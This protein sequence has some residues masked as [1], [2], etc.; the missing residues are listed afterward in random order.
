MVILVTAV[1]V[2]VH[3][4]ALH[5]RVLAFMIEEVGKST[6]GRFDLGDF[7]FRW[8]GLR[9][10]LDRPLLHGTEPAGTPPLFAAN[11]V[12]VNFSV[13]SWLG[14]E[15]RLRGV[16][17]DHPAVHLIVDRYGHSNI[18]EPAGK[19]SPSQPVDVFHLG[20][21]HFGLDQGTVLFND[22]Q[23]PLDADL[24]NVDAQARYVGRGPKYECSLS[25]H[26]GQVRYGHWN[27]AAHSLDTQFEA[28]PAGLETHHLLLTVGSSQVS[29]QGSL[30]DYA[31]PEVQATYQASL[32]LGD[33]RRILKLSGMP[34]GKLGTH[35]VLHYASTPGQS[36]LKSIVLDGQVSG[37]EI[38][39]DLPQ[40][41]TAVRLESARYHLAG[42]TA[43]VRDAVAALLGGQVTADLSIENLTA[44][45][46]AYHLASALK[47]ISLGEVS[48]ALRGR[49]PEPV[50]IAG[51]VDGQADLTWTGA[52]GSLMVRSDLDLRGSATAAS[53]AIPVQGAVHLNYDAARQVL[54]FQQSDLRTPH[55]EVR[56][57]GTLSNQSQLGIQARSDDLHEVDELILEVR[58]VNLGSGSETPPLPL[59]LQGSATFDGALQGSLNAPQLSGR[60]T[61]ER[62]QAE[63]T[64]WSAFR[65]QVSVSPWAVS[66]EQAVLDVPQSGGHIAFDFHTSLHGWSYQ[67]STPLSIDASAVNVPLAQLMRMA[68]LDY[69]IS[70]MLSG[71]LSFKGTPMHPVGQGSAQMTAVEIKDEPVESVNVEVQG[72]GEALHSTISLRAAAGS[73][74]AQVTYY[75]ANQAYDLQLG[76]RRIHLERLRTLSDLRLPL[77]G[78]VTATAQGRGTLDQPQIQIT[79]DS[80]QLT[81]NLPNGAQEAQS[82]KAQLNV[83]K[84][85]ASFTANANLGGTLE[86]RGTVDL[87]GDYNASASL[88]TSKIALAP[89]LDRYLPAEASDLQG[90][91]EIHATVTGPLK[92]PA[93][94]VAH[95]EIS[96]LNLAYQNISLANRAP[97]KLGYARGLL[98]I[99][100]V[101][102]EGSSTD[103]R[104]DGSVPLL[105]ALRTTPMRINA[106]GTVDLKILKLFAPNVDSSGQVTLSFSAQGNRSH[107]EFQGEVSVLNGTIYTTSLPLGLSNLNG[108]L[109]VVG[110]HLQVRQLTGQL[111]G[112]D[113]QVT[114]FVSYQPNI[115][116]A[117]ALNASTVR[118]RYPLGVRTILDTNL[119]LTGTPKSAR[120]TGRVLI[121]RLSLTKEFDLLT[122][123]DQLTAPA[124]PSPSNSFESH[125]RL[126][127]GVQSTEELSLASSKLSMQGSANLRMGGTAATPVIVGRAVVNAG[128]VY[129]R[130]QRYQVQQGVFD[131][132]DPYRTEPTVNL[133][134]S[135]NIDQYDLTMNLVGPMDRLR[136]HYS[137]V[138]PLPPVDIINLLA[139]GRT[140]TEQ[141]A[142]AGS[143]SN[144]M[145]AESIL[146]QGLSSAV[147]S[148]IERLVGIS[149]LQIDPLLGGS[150]SEPGARLAIQQRVTRNLS[151]TYATDVRTTGRE[152]IQVE[153]R[154]TRRWSLSLTRD[155]YGTYGIDVRGRKTF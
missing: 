141:A 5:R 23:V 43:Q 136:I 1:Y 108:Q 52:L 102:F 95:V 113:V 6:G 80:P 121:N 132:I 129:F 22:Q 19:P 97:L 3:S 103:L 70:G 17:I 26:D 76:A 78:L 114:G 124:P 35:G 68:K 85:H 29:A 154:L 31:K 10:D 9:L 7:N 91:A 135:T 38:A 149:N 139:T 27:P 94:V 84:R 110:N 13:I 128:E 56:L 41:K 90:Q 87:T 34:A 15:V 42:G 77:E 138:P 142:T 69:P 106:N 140:A 117:L 8:S 55:A 107:P 65:A 88:N 45:R 127:V 79:L 81:Y 20:I 47:Q 33:L 39:V 98:T 25:Y 152:V 18:P 133:T 100:P 37:S 92:R 60:I 63:G 28:A 4:P 24:R 131:F 49:V 134:L 11:R 145:G 62:L 122:I 66:V 48:R 112:G 101:S 16:T 99:E 111:G 151:F 2:A 137:S 50:P 72:V 115:T 123:A 105:P 36:F 64:S 73:A 89:L 116:F 126:D 104:L 67:A 148:R 58:R 14:R 32:V 118:L 12:T 57:S 82:I 46:P 144:T 61:A 30:R 74:S 83:A 143:V 93:D 71:R 75:P 109:Q 96:S 40:L 86:A 51:A 153:Y 120:L 155:E 147:S 150:N 59:A 146:A 130:G 125:L 44:K 119:Q 54:T 53:G 21:Q